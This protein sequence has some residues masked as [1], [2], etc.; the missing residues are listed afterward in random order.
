MN[1]FLSSTYIDLKEYRKAAAE[2]LERLG[3]HLGRMEVLGAR[4]VEPIQ[5]CF[6]EIESCDLFVGIY[7]YR[8]GYIL[9]DTQLSITEQEYNYAKK[10]QKPIFCFIV[11]DEYPWP[12]KMIENEPGKSKLQSFKSRIGKNLMYDKFTFPEDL[13]FKIATSI[14]RYLSQVNPPDTLQNSYINLL[15][16]SGDLV[17]LLEIALHELVRTTETDYNQIFLIITSAYSS[18]LV[19]VADMIPRH[20]Q[21][22]RIATFAG[23]LGLAYSSGKTVNANNVHERSNYFQAIIETKSEIVVPIKGRGIVF[24]VLNSES[25]EI[26]HY[27]NAIQHKL[28]QLASALGDLLPAVGWNP[29]VFSKDVP[30]IQ[31][32][33]A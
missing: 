3:Y 9:P 14:G 8:Y 12:P 18:Q 17:E 26:A 31:R 33:P 20:K 5:V 6:K 23:L 7:A 21:R 2:A 1:V 27:D 29:G 10:L 25:E 4:P 28:E 19:A 24:G 16:N 32:F 30:W 15:K 11:N 22:Y 13:A